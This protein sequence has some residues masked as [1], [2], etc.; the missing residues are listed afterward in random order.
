[1]TDA[2]ASK[3]Y[4]QGGP[5]GPSG[6]PDIVRA[7]TLLVQAP[8]QIDCAA[9]LESHDGSCAFRRARRRQSCLKTRKCGT[10]SWI[11]L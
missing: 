6:M 3:A 4:A 1:M 9:I 10:R 5:F 2:N 8:C 11:R 7:I